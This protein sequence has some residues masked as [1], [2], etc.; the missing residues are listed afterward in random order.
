MSIIEEYEQFLLIFC[1]RIL[2][3]YLKGVGEGIAYR[4]DG[5][6]LGWDGWLQSVEG[7]YI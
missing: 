6:E 2:P 3:V 5:K 4:R 1:K 7:K